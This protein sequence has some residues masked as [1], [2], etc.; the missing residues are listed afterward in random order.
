MCN[1]GRL[2]FLTHKR[3]AIS[4][5][6]WSFQNSVG[7]TAQPPES[8]QQLEILTTSAKLDVVEIS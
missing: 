1:K 5:A 6:C 4:A 2:L 3:R 7:C 8:A